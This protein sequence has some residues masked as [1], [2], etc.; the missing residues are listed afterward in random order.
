MSLTRD[1]PQGGSV[2]PTKQHQGALRAPLNDMLGTEAN[3]RL[4]RELAR[5]RRG[6]TAGA[7]ADRARL[8]RAA[9]YRALDRLLDTGIVEYSESGG[10]R[11]CRLRSEHPLA[12]ALRGLFHFEADR[13]RE[14]EKG[15][16]A[17][18]EALAPPPISGWIEGPVARGDDR[19]GTPL[20]VGLLDTP[21]H[22]DEHAEALRDQLVAL[23]READVTIEVRAR[24]L[25][26][27]DALPDDERDALVSAVPLFGVPVEAFVAPDRLHRATTTRAHGDLDARGLAYASAIAERLPTEPELIDRALEWVRARLADASTGEARELREWERI[28]SSS[29]PAR[30]RRF[31]LHPG[32]RAT[33]LRQSN[34][35]LAILTEEERAELRRRGAA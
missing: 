16:R 19:F 32:E 21:Q 34:P 14:I 26:D 10:S 23:E 8:N 24:T 13:F 30:L 22:L 25:A 6:L 20:V 7:L 33:R 28:L 29:T 12:G 4:L 3:V 17:A 9:T 1:A 35:F 5:A 27:L 18:L 11:R 15:I 31:L 2:R